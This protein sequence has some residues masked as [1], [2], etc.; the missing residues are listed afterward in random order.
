VPGWADPQHQNISNSNHEMSGRVEE[1]RRS[2]E[3]LGENERELARTEL[4]AL[5]VGIP[6]PSAMSNLHAPPPVTSSSTST[7]PTLHPSSSGSDTNSISNKLQGEDAKIAAQI[8]ATREKAPSSSDDISEK[9]PESAS[10][11]PKKG[12]F[13]RRKAKD[14]ADKKSKEKEGELNALPPVKLFALW[15][16]A[17]KFEA[18]LNVIGLI[19]AAAAGA[20]QPL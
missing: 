14:K 6:L 2:V 18:V 12:F 1:H 16:F 11:K 3:H 10:E 15:R 4:T 5:P 20:A 7:A 13:A 8:A 17:T 19:L 9:H